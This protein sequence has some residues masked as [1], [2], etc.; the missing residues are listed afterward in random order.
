MVVSPLIALME[1]Q[2][3]ALR[4][5][6]VPAAALHSELPAEE[7][8]AARRMLQEGRIKLLHISPER[9]TLPHT[10]EALGPAAAGPLRR[11]RGALHQPMGASLPARI[12]RADRPALERFPAVPRLA[13]TATADPR[14]VEDIR[15]QLGLEAAAVFRG[16]FDR[17][18]IRLMPR[19]GGRNGRSCAPS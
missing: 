1:D 15:R 2:V 7:A 5:Q 17:P 10:L 9:L 6:G 19:R 18:N 13:L 11:G 3:A 14:T 16:G 4:Q 12:P 8:A